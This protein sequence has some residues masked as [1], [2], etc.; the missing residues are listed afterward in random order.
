MKVACIK[1]IF[2][3]LIYSKQ[4]APEQRAV[5]D[6]GVALSQDIWPHLDEKCREVE[7]DNKWLFL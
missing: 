7:P 4:L 5:G 6:S 2:D 3:S 1:E